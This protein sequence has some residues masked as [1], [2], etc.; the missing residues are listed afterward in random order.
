MV[1]RLIKN[2]WP[3]SIDMLRQEKGLVDGEKPVIITGW[4]EEN[5]RYEQ[6]LLGE[7]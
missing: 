6:F 7:E 4:T 5:A 3:H 1:I 2:F